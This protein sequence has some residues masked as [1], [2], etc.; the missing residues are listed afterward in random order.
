MDVILGLLALGWDV[1]AKNG[2]T[3]LHEAA[4]HARGDL[5]EALIAA[6]ADPSILDDSF[7][8]TPAGWAEHFGHV[9]IQ[10]VLDGLRR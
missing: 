2:T 4:M 10:R 5:V 1:N 6:G 9:E 7:H 8:A 3:A